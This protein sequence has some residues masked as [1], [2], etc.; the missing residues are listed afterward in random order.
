MKQRSQVRY[1]YAHC[2]QAQDRTRWSKNFAMDRILQRIGGA[3]DC[4]LQLVAARQRDAA[5]GETYRC[6]VDD[7]ARGKAA[8]HAV[9]H[10]GREEQ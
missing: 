7:V 4:D 2:G 8:D 3:A 9:R 1:R 6:E 10:G 5:A